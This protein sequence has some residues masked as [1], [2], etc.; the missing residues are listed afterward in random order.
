MMRYRS[1]LHL[2]AAHKN[3][4]GNHKPSLRGSQLFD[5][6]SNPEFLR[7]GIAI[8]DFFHPDRIVCGVESRR[9]QRI[10]ET[11][12]ASFTC[13]IL[14]TDLTTAELI[15]HTANAFLAAKISFIN[16]V[17]DVCDAV[18]ADVGMVA[19]G[20]GLDHRIGRSFLN[21]GLGYGG[22]CLPKDVAAFIK[23]GRDNGVDMG[24]LKAVQSVNEERV[25]RLLT[26]LREAVWILRGKTIGIWGLSFKAGTDDV[27]E[28][29]SLRV[30]EELLKSGAKVRAYDPK[31]IPNARAVLAEIPGQ[32][33]YVDRPAEC[34]QG[35]SAIV[36]LT[37]WPEFQHADFGAL[38]EMMEIAVIV[39]GRNLLCPATA[40]AAGFEY[41][42]MGCSAE[43][44]PTEAESESE[45]SPSAA[46]AEAS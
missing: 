12:Y 38:R 5:V 11:L 13:P 8:H 46:L 42:C 30:I 39:D 26:K 21:A 19:K 9:A 3:G 4:N 10:L 18:G 14:F 41:Y 24:L 17:S 37:E 25:A 45:D 7:E 32:L 27:R 28:A 20:I 36:I 43:P 6:A 40:Q 15:K 2:V 35:A 22:Y 23:V 1:G 44:L 33:E 29:P 34:A 16:M 31:A